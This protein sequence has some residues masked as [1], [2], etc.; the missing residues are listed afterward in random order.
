MNGISTYSSYSSKRSYCLKQ[1]LKRKIPT[2]APTRWFF[3]SCLINVIHKHRLVIVD[4][5]YK[6]SKDL[7]DW[8]AIDREVA[9]GFKQF[10]LKI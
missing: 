10:F 1:F 9:N 8:N 5:F 4:Y 7:K 2:L 6:I 3:T